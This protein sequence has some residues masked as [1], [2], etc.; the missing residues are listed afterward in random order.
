MSF[1][2]ATFIAAVVFFFASS[3]ASPLRRNVFFRTGAEA[4]SKVSGPVFAAAP[5][6]LPDRSLWWSAPRWRW[7]WGELEQSTEDGSAFRRFGAN[8]GDG[9]QLCAAPF[10]RTLAF[11]LVICRSLGDHACFKKNAARRQKASPKRSKKNGYGCHAPS[12]RTQS[13]RALAHGTTA[14]FIKKGGKNMKIGYSTRS[15]RS[16]KNSRGRYGAWRVLAGIGRR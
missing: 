10:C 1:C 5:M 8:S 4:N 12:F 13:K 6:R 7:G 2:R 3:G 11:A 15:R 9:G 16:E 14:D